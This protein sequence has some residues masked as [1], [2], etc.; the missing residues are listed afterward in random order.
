MPATRILRTL[1]FGV[2]MAVAYPM[3]REERQ[4]V[5]AFLGTNEA[6]A[7]PP[8]SAFCAADR[9]I[10]PA[11]PE[12][13]WN[14]WSAT[15]SNTRFQASEAAGLTAAQLGRLTLKWAFGFGRRC[16]RICGA[17]RPQRHDVRRQRQWHGPRTR[18]P[19]GMPALDLPG[20][21]PRALGAPRCRGRCTTNARL[22]RSDRMGVRARCAHRARAMEDTDRGA[23]SHEAHR[24]SSRAQRSGVRARGL[25]GRDPRDRS[26]I[27][28][29]H[30]PRQRHGA[31]RSR[32]IASVEDVHG[33]SAEADG[34]DEPRY[35]HLWAVGRRHLGR[36][37]G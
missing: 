20:E 15:P 37:D 29:L 28:V 1:D 31:S 10:M 13:S 22:R 25:V 21:R 5:A 17:H 16:H 2:M 32:R 30:V 33:R 3:R 12:H 26:R 4:A 27:P 34:H 11:P 9:A 23:R 6:E 18:R 35:R 14:G 36:A 24:I 19:H 7:T 8:P